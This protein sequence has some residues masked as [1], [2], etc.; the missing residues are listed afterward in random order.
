MDSLNQTMTYSNL[1]AGRMSWLCN[2][3]DQATYYFLTA[4]NYL[5]GTCIRTSWDSNKDLL[6]TSCAPNDEP[7][8]GLT[9]LSFYSHPPLANASCNK[10]IIQRPFSSKTPAFSGCL[11]FEFFFGPVLFANETSAKRCE[12]LITEQEWK[13]IQT[14]RRIDSLVCLT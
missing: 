12:A 6:G 8:N 9:G 5:D 4:R 11:L 3:A 2:L 10:H 7:L 1:A 13:G 14:A